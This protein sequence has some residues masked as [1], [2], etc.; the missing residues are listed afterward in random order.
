MQNINV[1]SQLGQKQEWK[2]T[3]KRTDTADCST[4]PANAVDN[5]YS[6]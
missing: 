1:K 5:K 4:L 2:Q 3:D 6:L